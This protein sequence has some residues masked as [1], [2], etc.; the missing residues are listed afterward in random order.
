MPIPVNC[1]KALL[2]RV[3]TLETQNRIWRIVGFLVLL[4]VGFS[5][6]ANVTAEQKVQDAPM[7]AT[8]VEAQK[9]LLKDAVGT[10]MGELTISDGKPVLGL[11]DRSGKVTWS[12]NTRVTASSR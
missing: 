1:E 5:R 7:R 4:T 10:L 11:Y 8:T 2:I 9:F 6:T 12:T 3:N